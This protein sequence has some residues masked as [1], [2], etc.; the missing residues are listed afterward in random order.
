M[1]RCAGVLLALQPGQMP[2]TQL[3]HAKGLVDMTM[4]MGQQSIMDP[5]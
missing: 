5:Q 1:T 2:A 3:R 4:R